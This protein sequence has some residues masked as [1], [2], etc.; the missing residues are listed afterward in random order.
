MDGA[1]TINVSGN[2]AQEFVDSF[3]AMISEIRAEGGE[4]AVKFAI[5]LIAG[6]FAAIFADSFVVKVPLIDPIQLG[7]TR[8]FTENSKAPAQLN[9]VG[10]GYKGGYGRIVYVAPYIEATEAELYNAIKEN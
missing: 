10:Y 2:N 4:E 6:V 9:E 7:C 1:V 8:F 5:T 3:N